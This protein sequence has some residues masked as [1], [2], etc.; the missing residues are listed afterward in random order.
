M[1]SSLVDQHYEYAT[2]QYDRGDYKGAIESIRVV[3]SRM[4][5]FSRAHA[6]LALCLLQEK[7]IAAA[8][9]E[10]SLAL[11]LDPQDAGNHYVQ[12]LLWVFRDRPGKALK[13]LD[14]AISLDPE[15]AAAYLV[16]VRIYLD[17]N[18]LDK[19]ELALQQAR[20]L[21]P[22]SLQA[23]IWQAR[24]YIARGDLGKALP[25]ID[26]VLREEPQS[27]SALCC[28]GMILLRQGE[29]EDARQHA[30]WALQVDAGNDEALHLL[31]STKARQ[32]F[33]IGLW[34]RYAVMLSSRPLQFQVL[35]LVGLFV[36]YR[37]GTMAAGDLGHTR[38]Q[39]TMGM[40]WLAFV[41]YTWVSPVIFQR[42]LDAELKSVE[43][44]RDY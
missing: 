4:P 21:E 6:L 32:N 18:M 10:A 33:L 24:L 30:I 26:D 35:L 7:R 42:M 41:V 25:V 29:V 1:D 44:S 36:L 3:L 8:E 37:F 20:S 39:S 27:V 43:L 13:C 22:D 23:K 34:W 31:V 19:A 40:L 17:E 15:S 9:H 11:Q 14:E 28:K 12:A 38:L 5:E 16:K 2:Q